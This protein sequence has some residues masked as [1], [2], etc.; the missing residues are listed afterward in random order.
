VTLAVARGQD[1]AADRKA[2]RSA[3][4]FAELADRYLAEYARKRNKSWAQARALISNHVL[5]HWSALQASTITRSDVK[6]LI[7]RI[8]APIAGNQTLAAISAIFS[9]AKREEIVLVNPCGSVERNPTRSRDRILADSEIPRFWAAASDA[10]IAGAALKMILLTGARPGEVMH[11][12]REHLVDGWWQLPGAP[13]P[14]LGW[15]GTKNGVTHRVWLS[16]PARA[17]AGDGAVGFVFAN[18]RGGAVYG[19]ATVMRAMAGK[20]VGGGEVELAVGLG[21]EPARPHDLR[22]TFGS[23]V[24]AAG[25]GR[26]AMDRILNHADHSVGSVYDRHSYVAEDRA[27]M[28]TIADKILALIEGRA[29][30]NVVALRG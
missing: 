25:F 11:M 10:G 6:T 18:A 19:L 23:M 27:I 22:R 30:D 7:A 24:T 4:T 17:L 1:P 9:W 28:E 12:R 5:P 21:A 16:G 3:G 15:P 2:E 29:A 13:V 14:E 20:L 26:Q 8:E